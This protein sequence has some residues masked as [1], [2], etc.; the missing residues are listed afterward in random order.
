MPVIAEAVRIVPLLGSGIPLIS[1]AATKALMIA[2]SVARTAARNNGVIL[3]FEM[4]VVL[5]SAVEKAMKISPEL[6]FV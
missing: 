1:S 6:L 2:S 3:A 5:G 4:A